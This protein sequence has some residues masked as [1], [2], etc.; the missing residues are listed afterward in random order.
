MAKR[1]RTPF[2]KKKVMKRKS[3]ARRVKNIIK[4]DI[5]VK[6]SSVKTE[7]AYASGTV[8]LG[9]NTLSV[10][11]TNI[12]GTNVGAFAPQT[13]TNANRVGDQI[14]VK[15]IRLQF[16]LQLDQH[17]PMA[18]YKIFVVKSASGD[19]PT[20][21]VSSDM[22]VN[23]TGN[24]MM[25]YVDKK[26][27][28]ILAQKSGS[29]IQRGFG[30]VGGIFAN[31]TGSGQV[32]A[33][34]AN[35]RIAPT[36]K[37]VSINLPGKLFGRAGN[38]TYLQSSDTPKFFSYTVHILGYSNGSKVDIGSASG[39]GLRLNCYTRRMYFTDQ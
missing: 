8:D 7:N 35:L 12:L 32:D 25:D 11:D 39:N 20:D 34:Q 19:R 18:S 6:M 27:F 31:E 24:N 36:E 23:L 14:T 15:G 17:Q 38:V 30:T 16:A 1:K 26:R 9:H 5:E 2:R 33:Q 28:T 4:R 3:F 10:L 37:I 13:T 22:F 21:G 29:I